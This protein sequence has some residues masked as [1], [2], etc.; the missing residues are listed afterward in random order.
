[1]NGLGGEEA[2]I[3]GMDYV[4]EKIN[5]AGGVPGF[6]PKITENPNNTDTDYKLDIETANGTFTTPNLMASVV[7]DSSLNYYSQNPVQNRVVTN[8]FD[9][10]VAGE[11]YIPVSSLQVFYVTVPLRYQEDTTGDKHLIILSD[12]LG[13]LIFVSGLSKNRTIKAYRVGT[14]AEPNIKKLYYKNLDDYYRA[15]LYIERTNGNNPI[16]IYGA[17]G[18]S[19][20][21]QYGGVSGLVEIEIENV[22]SSCV[23]DELLD[24]ES[25]NAI[26]NKAVAEALD[27]IMNT[28]ISIGDL[29]TR[30][31]LSISLVA[32]ED[33]TQQIIDALDVREQFVEWFGNSNDRFGINPKTYGDRINELRI[34]KTTE[35]NAIITAIMNSGAVLSRLYTDGALGDWTSTGHILADG[36]MDDGT[37]CITGENEDSSGM[38]GNGVLPET[39]GFSRDAMTWANG[40]YRISHGVDLVGLPENLQSGRLEHFNLKR[41]QNNANP[42]SATWADR[43]S[44]FY[45]DNGNIYTRLQISGATAGVI[46]SDTGW[47]CVTQNTKALVTNAQNFKI[48]LTKRNAS[49]YGMFTFNFMYGAMPCEITF[50][51]SDK[52]YY[53]ITKGQN[54]VSAITYTQDGANYQ[55]GIDFTTKMYGT[56]VVEMPSEFGTINSLTAETFAGATSAILKGYDGKSYTSLM[57]LGLTADATIQDVMDALH[58]GGN[59]I[60][61][62]DS[63]TNWSTLFNGIQWGYLKIE[64]TVNGMCLIELTEVLGDCRMYYGK[65][66]SGKFVEWQRINTNEILHT[67][68]SGNLASITTVLDLVNALLTEYRALSSKK[69]IKFVSGEITKTTL[70]DLPVSY[71]LLQITVSGWDVV[72]VRLAHSSNGFKS[73]YYGFV[74][75]ITGQEL[76]SSITWEKVATT[77]YVDNGGTFNGKTVKSVTIDLSV[78]AFQNK[79]NTNVPLTSYISAN[80]N[81]IKAEGYVNATDGFG[82]LIGTEWGSLNCVFR[83]VDN[84]WFFLAKGYGDDSTKK[85]T[86]FMKLYYI[87]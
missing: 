30:K 22:S 45:S 86:G 81:I 31:G 27:G 29:N 38:Y 47:R 75:R 78:S 33:N 24:I 9:K 80:A 64:K 23:I 4:D 85:N 49:W 74:N 53:T 25:T 63:F 17:T 58:I 34:I 37:I 16:T 72:E 39:L 71:G 48:D 83:G 10:T 60:I 19:S 77:D 7:V 44:I 54:V 28:Y 65:Q 51:I 82:H 57:E 68:L 79:N 14:V 50:T 46:T 35:T 32:N 36:Y 5:G 20:Y 11:V 18:A 67:T 70:T 3:L 66:G 76:I 84:I 56:Q 6:S 41:W 55:I 42:H 2:L 69:P 59:A 15:E 13:D 40:L 12:S 26:Q 87:E 52:V 21:T 1:M 8:K 43:M 61:R 73:M 62:T